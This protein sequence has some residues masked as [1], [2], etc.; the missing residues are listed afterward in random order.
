M[1]SRQIA[2]GVVGLGA[3][4]LLAWNTWTVSR[5]ASQVGALEVAVS[6]ASSAAADTRGERL[7]QAVKPGRGGAST[8]AGSRASGGKAAGGKGGVGKSAG[9]KAG[10]AQGAP[11]DR[12]QRFERVASQWLAMLELE[13]EDFAIDEGLSDAEADEILAELDELYET[14]GQVRSDVK[15]GGLPPA[16]AKAELRILKEDAD[17]RLRG[18]LGDERHAALQERLRER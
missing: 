11:R 16:E 10:R 1:D 7:P 3:C 5:L 2:A 8:A 18:L 14:L 17:Q 6:R 13:V 4:G 12:E 9:T 15:A